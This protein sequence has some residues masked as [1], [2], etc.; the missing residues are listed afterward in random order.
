[1][2]F[3]KRTADERVTTEQNKLYAQ[4]YNWLL[5]L[6]AAMVIVKLFIDRRFVL[7][8]P[9]IIGGGGSLLLLLILYAYRGVLFQRGGDERTEKFIVQ[10]K[11]ICH[12]FAS[13]ASLLSLIV[14]LELYEMHY[15]FS[16]AHLLFIVPLP[17]A[18][19]RSV[20]RGV[21]SYSKSKKRRLWSN[22]WPAFI[23]A[24]LYFA[25]DTWRY[26]AH[27]IAARIAAA[28]FVSLALMLLLGIPLHLYETHLI[29]KNQKYADRQ[30]RDAEAENGGDGV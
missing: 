21:Y 22:L 16:G 25:V 7:F 30:L 23:G 24:L 8:L 18:I 3:A 12:V 14:T 28:V 11:A 9:E 20:K 26:P 10:S 19:T 2:K 5:S 6:M 4:T 29:R 13:I 15:L 17:L 1:M 27:G